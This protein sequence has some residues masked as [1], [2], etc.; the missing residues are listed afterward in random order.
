MRKGDRVSFKGR[1]GTVVGFM[2]QGMV[3]VR[4]D[5][6]SHRVERRAKS[7]LHRAG[8]ATKQNPRP[9]RRTRLRARRNS[10]DTPETE[11]TK[12]KQEAARAKAERSR[13]LDEIRSEISRI[14]RFDKR[15]RMEA[16]PARTLEDIIAREKAAVFTR[17]DPPRLS[18]GKNAYCGNPIDN[19]AYYI[20]V[21][22]STSRITPW[23]TWDQVKEA[24]EAA[25]VK[26]S[27]KPL[28]FSF[29][30]T[31]GTNVGTL[32]R[33]EVYPK[34]AGAVAE[35]GLLDLG[36]NPL[37]R[38][39]RQRDDDMELDRVRSGTRAPVVASYTESLL[40]AGS[41]L[42][43]GKSY[44]TEQ[45][46]TLNVIRGQRVTVEVMSPETMK[47]LIEFVHQGYL[48]QMAN[49][50]GG[51]IFPTPMTPSKYFR[52]RSGKKGQRPLREEELVKRYKKP[53]NA[54][55]MPILGQ[56][57][58][59][60][61]PRTGELIFFRSSQ[62]RALGRDFLNRFQPYAVHRFYPGVPSTP[63][64]KAE[65]DISGRGAVSL[66]VGA[67]KKGIHIPYPVAIALIVGGFVRSGPFVHLNP[68]KELNLRKAVTISFPGKKDSPF[69]SWV[70][71][72]V[73]L[74]YFTTEDETEAYKGRPTARWG[75]CLSDVQKKQKQYLKTTRDVLKSYLRALKQVQNL[76]NKISLSPSSFREEREDPLRPA[77]KNLRY[78]SD[79]RRAIVQLSFGLQ[80]TERWFT[81]LDALA[82]HGDIAAQYVLDALKESALDYGNPLSPF[83]QSRE[84]FT[85]KTRFIT[86][87]S[88]NLQAV[89]SIGL[90]S[91]AED[92]IDPLDYGS[93][94]QEIES[95]L[96]DDTTYFEVL[97]GLF[98]EI[99]DQPVL[100]KDGTPRLPGTT[101]ETYAEL[102]PSFAA[103]LALEPSTQTVAPA[104]MWLAGANLHPSLG[105]YPYVLPS[106]EE[107]SAAKLHQFMEANKVNEK[108][109]GLLRDL[110]PVR[111]VYS[112]LDDIADPNLDA[113]H[114][115]RK[116]LGIYIEGGL[117]GPRN[118]LLDPLSPRSDFFLVHPKG[119][120][121]DQDYQY[122]LN[123]IVNQAVTHLYPALVWENKVP[124]PQARQYALELGLLGYIYLEMN[125]LELAGSL[126]PSEH[127]EKN[128]LDSTI[129][130]LSKEIIET[131]GGQGMIAQTGRYSVFKTYNPVLF[132]ITRAFWPKSDADKTWGSIFAHWPVVKQIDTVGRYGY[133][134]QTLQKIALRSSDEDEVTAALDQRVAT[135][136]GQYVTDVLSG[137]VKHPESGTT[138]EAPKG[139]Y[140]TFLKLWPIAAP[141]YRTKTFDH[142]ETARAYAYLADLVQQ[143]LDALKDL[144]R[145]TEQAISEAVR[146]RSFGL[147]SQNA[148]LTGPGSDYILAVLSGDAP[149]LDP[150]EPDPVDE[151]G[152]P[153][154]GFESEYEARVALRRALDD[155][156]LAF[157]EGQRR[158]EEP[159]EVNRF[160]RKRRRKRISRATMEIVDQPPLPE[161]YVY[162]APTILSL[163]EDKQAAI[164]PKQPIPF[165]L[166]Q[167]K[168][169]KRGKEIIEIGQ[170]DYFDGIPEEG[171]EGSALHR[172]EEGRPTLREMLQEIDQA[173][174][175]LEK[176]TK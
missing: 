71:T 43:D 168:L 152:R 28:S 147:P 118:R 94:K 117:V 57:Y 104:F 137:I 150:S 123:N 70:Q 93:L 53:D 156:L 55:F 146:L 125:G 10:D 144:R 38:T 172:I 72:D 154:T 65:A 19:T 108:G 4:F 47:N 21:D 85:G 87:P 100:F 91:S 97:Q 98:K 109:V 3:D 130:M 16:K 165:A 17:P 96:L 133:L 174:A 12:R 115:L 131:M 162:D 48:T 62:T 29:P 142:P 155:Q 50:S 6:A 105:F 64:E 83:N 122:T 11:E 32:L 77:T 158:R 106:L 8:S 22:D 23:V 34:V 120:S 127:K 52:L 61:D 37:R 2:P 86:L 113:A 18:E 159:K 80:S 41:L 75:P 31:R 40:A 145:Q 175:L 138:L 81:R 66:V 76:V 82:L 173:I 27:K 176:K 20:I 69:F 107:Q 30:V 170:K 164:A 111:R 79:T 92:L 59:E 45:A 110:A 60:V 135:Y 88:G 26:I 56:A 134:A 141:F 167:R 171:I 15:K 166:S 163:A 54:A 36:L 121:T 39:G 95:Q 116:L 35:S 157:S 169:I 5:D 49:R 126:R 161:G 51:N 151:K 136:E 63:E 58:H 103:S 33:E 140:D 119:Y 128:I 153:I 7:D 73:P 99:T 160:R 101:P 67:K 44:P 90:I 114:N 13:T 139:Y 102:Q 46:N 74:T 42:I 1:I 129:D 14:D 112:S 68:M 78:L 124:P 9:R 84:R 143:P 149:A 132:E 89:P 25:K 148:L 24:A